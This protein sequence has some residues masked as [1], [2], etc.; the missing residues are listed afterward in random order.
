MGYQF[1]LS[2]RWTVGLDG[3]FGAAGGGGVNAAGGVVGSVRGVLD[4]RLTEN[5][6][7]SLGLG[8]LRT[9][10]SSGMSTN[11][12]TLGVKIPFTTR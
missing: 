6:A 12:A 8:Q 10:R 2:P 1:G 5:V 9:L 4:F 3:R 7:L 11:F